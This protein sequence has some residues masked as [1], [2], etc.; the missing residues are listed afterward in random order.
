MHT[1]M[2]LIALAAEVYCCRNTKV[3]KYPPFA[4]LKKNQRMAVSSCLCFHSLPLST[5]VLLM[6]LL[7]CCKNK[8]AFLFVFFLI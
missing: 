4:L 8:V 1:A 2:H 7:F 3:E 5:Y 6:I